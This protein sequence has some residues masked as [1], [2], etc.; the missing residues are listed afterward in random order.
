MKCLDD[1]ERGSADIALIMMA[2]MMFIFVVTSGTLV[3]R[4]LGTQNNSIKASL[5]DALK[6][7]VTAAISSPL[8]QAGDLDPVIMQ[9]TITQIFA[10][11]MNINNGNVTMETFQVYTDSD[12][13]APAPVEIGGTIPGRSVYVSL[14]VTWTTP[15]IIGQHYTGTYHVR[16]L[17][18][19]PIYFAPGKEWN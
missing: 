2:V 11:K 10:Q 13:G 16:K 19:L 7:A 18:A 3:L 17:V 8:V 6:D 5:E 15:S 1:K 14:I 9:T 12:K 4:V